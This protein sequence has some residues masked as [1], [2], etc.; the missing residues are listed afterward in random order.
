DRLNELEIVGQVMST[1]TNYNHQAIGSVQEA[2][3]F[4]K[5]AGFPEHGLVIMV[6]PDAKEETQIIKGIK[7]EAT[8]TAAVT[9]ALKR[10]PTG[11]VHI[12]TDMRALHNPTRMKNIAKATQNL[13][14][15]L[16]HLCPTCG[17]PGFEVVSEHTG[18]SC[19]LC[20]LPTQLVRSA[21]YQCRRCAFTQEIP[22]P[23]G[24]KEAD[25]AYCLYC[26]P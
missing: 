6:T 14:S 25:P 26:N 3:E 15:R 17:H 13:V 19:S 2:Y 7:T 16:N 9:I 8:L 21:V 20:G 5:R 12:E 4:A 10:S 23:Q 24:V 18:L 1:D 11:K 22:F